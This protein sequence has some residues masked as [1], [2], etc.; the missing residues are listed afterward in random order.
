MYVFS[1][2]QNI[3]SKMKRSEHCLLL[4]LILFYP[5]KLA[6]Q[7]HNAPFK[8]HDIAIGFTT[9]WANKSH[10]HDA[11]LWCEHSP[12]MYVSY[13]YNV[14]RWFGV[15]VTM[16]VVSEHEVLSG[17]GKYDRADMLSDIHDI[18]TQI[19]NSSHYP[20]DYWKLEHLNLELEALKNKYEDEFGKYYNDDGSENFVKNHSLVVIPFVRFNWHRKCL[21]VGEKKKTVWNFGMYS[22]IG[23]GMNGIIEGNLC[24]AYDKRI[25]WELMFRP[26]CIEAG[27]QHIRLNLE[28]G[29]PTTVGLKVGL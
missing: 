25:N 26:F 16:H 8:R 5:L 27:W 14:T 19:A 10:H 17:H 13:A 2:S 7:D 20:N 11:Y 23:Y 6:A 4:L 18:E 28:L 29:Y 22:D 21:Y 9:G 15:G 12:S 24:T 1:S 3:F